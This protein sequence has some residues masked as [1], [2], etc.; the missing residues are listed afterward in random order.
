MLSL[1][2]SVGD[3]DFLCVSYAVNRLNDIYEIKQIQRH[4]NTAPYPDIIHISS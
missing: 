3:L 4:G 2:N 1:P